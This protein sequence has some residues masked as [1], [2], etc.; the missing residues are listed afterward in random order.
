MITFKLAEDQATI[1]YWALYEKY[2]QLE[3]RVREF[4]HLMWP[5]AAI[6][7]AAWEANKL[8]EVLEIMKNAKDTP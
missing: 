2:M 1:V 5:D 4:K 7:A 3:T 8:K 6:N